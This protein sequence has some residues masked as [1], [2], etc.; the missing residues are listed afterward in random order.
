MKALIFPN[1]PLIEYVRKGEI[2]K[3][4]F[5][6]GNI[7]SEIHFVTFA[8]EEC[9]IEDI[10]STIGNAKGYIHT[11]SPL[12]ITE[13][14]FPKK[15]IN[16]IFNHVCNLDINIIR[17][18]NPLLQGLITVR[19]AKKLNI[20]SI[21]SIHI[22][23]DFD[24]RKIDL[25]KKRLRFFKYFI[26]K[27]LYEKEVLRNA[28]LIFPA[29]QF[30]AQYAIDNGAS[31]DK[32]HVIYNKINQEIYY[33]IEQ[34]QSSTP[35][36]I[37][38]VGRLIPEKGQIRLIEALA[39]LD[40]NSSLTIVGNGPDYDF[41]MQKINQLNLQYRIKIIQKVDNKELPELYRK[42]D[43]FSLPI[44]YGGICIPVLEAISCGL[45]LVMPE[46]QFE[47]EPEVIHQTGMIVK[48][49]PKAFSQAFKKIQKDHS[50]L[51][52]IKKQSIE[53]SINFNQ[54]KLEQQEKEMIVHE[55]SSAH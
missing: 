20:K 14:L 44:E 19:L 45:A 15:I 22:N 42:H 47:T 54:A 23:F 36:K 27:Y 30:A 38:S 4:Y 28:D 1:D 39:L 17:A 12:K 26:S 9:S 40:Q 29:Y 33:P 43:V 13:Q 41:L 7:Y 18:Y 49:N 31:T 8:N 32:V 10:Q 24:V 50:L 21:I 16:Q 25:K 37:I 55:T 51:K 48:N 6:P 46:S 3:N 11:F 52:K 34:T 53:L 5:N 35:L 2:K